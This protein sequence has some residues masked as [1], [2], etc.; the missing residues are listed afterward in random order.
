MLPLCSTLKIS[1]RIVSGSDALC[2]FRYSMAF[3]ISSYRIDSSGSAL[4]YIWWLGSVDYLARYSLAQYFLHTLA[5]SWA[6]VFT[7]PFLSQ[8]TCL[9]ALNSR[10][11]RLTF[12]KSKCVSFR[13]VC[14]SF[15]LQI[16]EMCVFLSLRESLL[17]RLMRLFL[18]FTYLL[19]SERFRRS[20]VAAVV[21]FVNQCR[22]FPEECFGRAVTD[23]YY[24][25]FLSSI[26][27]FWALFVFDSFGC[28]EARIF[29]SSATL[30]V[31]AFETSI[32]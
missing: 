8:I 18:S 29:L 23:A 6:S 24:T 28:S 20:S 2:F 19:V 3:T 30:K 15:S 4:P 12:W 10:D 27:C 32:F 25:C 21:S 26:Y 22:H 16:H 31:S 11:T 1:S 17:R 13:S 7:S 5:I 14:V 9:L